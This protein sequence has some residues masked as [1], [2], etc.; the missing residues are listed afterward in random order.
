MTATRPP[1]RVSTALCRWRQQR[2]KVR[3]SEW[4]SNILLLFHILPVTC[5]DAHLFFPVF[6][7]KLV[8]YSQLQG[9]THTDGP[10]QRLVKEG[11]IEAKH[12]PSTLV[13]PLVGWSCIIARQ[14]STSL[15]ICAA[16]LT[17]AHAQPRTR[18]RTHFVYYYLSIHACA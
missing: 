11:V 2:G 15:H 7:Q 3:I 9:A 4:A 10:A 8:F 5:I 1:P 12:L 14:C 16:S 18:S 6:S 17:H 13:S